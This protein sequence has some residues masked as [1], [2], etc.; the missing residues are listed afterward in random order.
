MEC[1]PQG[2]T[3]LLI[4]VIASLSWLASIL[5]DFSKGSHTIIWI[6]VLISQ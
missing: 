4:N 6:P 1:L 2:L 3:Y 5:K